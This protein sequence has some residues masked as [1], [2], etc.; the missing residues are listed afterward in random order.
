M[1]GTNKIHL[2]RGRLAGDHCERD[3]IWDREI[4]TASEEQRAAIASAAWER[5]LEHLAEGSDFY[6]RKFREEG[7]G[8]G[9]VALADITKLPFTTKDELR[10]AIEERPPFGSNAGV[11]PEQIKRVYQTSGTTGS[12]T[13]I[14]LSQTDLETWTAVG[15]RTYYATGIHDHHSVLTTFGAG[16]FVAGHTH[17]ILSRVG[18][19]TVPVA[20]G[21]TNRVLFG[22][23]AGLAD[24]LLATPSFA[25]YLANRLETSD[26]DSTFHG[27]VHVVTGGEPGGGIPA[28]RDHIERVL[29]VTVNEVMGIGDVAPSLFGECPSQQGMHFCGTGH[30]WPE[31]VDS[32]TREPMTIEAGAVGE[33]VYTHLTREAMPVVRFLSG[34]I[35]RIEGT[36]CE[37][38]RTGFRMRCLARRDD[39]FIVRGVKVYPAAILAVVGEFRPRVTGRARVVRRGA[40]VT[41]DPPVPIEVEVPGSGD[42]DAALTAEIEDAVHDRLTFR[43]RVL[44]VAEQTFGESGYKTKLSVTRP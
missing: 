33:L 26:P 5:Q 25:Q 6:S 32:A 29:G 39:M 24:T 4:E 15:S 9:K 42:G 34:D 38:G 22:L 35:V 44:L 7:V 13:V 2:S 11:A 28:I 31:L 17:L 10:K 23:K 16:P 37:C 19:R 8:T 14:A 1:P 21:D 18:A 30:V 3:W 12:P 36:S 20:P 41:V 27:L 40:Q 43:C